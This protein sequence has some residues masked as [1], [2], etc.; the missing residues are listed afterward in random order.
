MASFGPSSD[1]E[2][3]EFNAPSHSGRS[4]SRVSFSGEDALL[5]KRMK[6]HEKTARKEAMYEKVAAV[7]PRSTVNSHSMS[8]STFTSERSQ[9][10]LSTN[11]AIR[12]KPTV[13]RQ[14]R[15]ASWARGGR[16]GAQLKSEKDHAENEG[17]L[18]AMQKEFRELRLHKVER[19]TEEE[20]EFEHLKRYVGAIALL[21]D[22][23][24]VCM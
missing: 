22:S 21:C 9:L 5:A 23:H 8:Q 13:P 1:P 4:H 20:V 11:Q 6:D 12:L 2:Q 14:P 24:G 16:R 15:V 7:K 10:S 17:Y 3:E 18:E 19:T